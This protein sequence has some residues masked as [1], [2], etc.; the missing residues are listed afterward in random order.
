MAMP[1]AK[2]ISEPCRKGVGFELYELQYAADFV[3]KFGPRWQAL[4]DQL[5]RSLIDTRR[6]C[7]KTF[8]LDDAARG[9]VDAS[10][11]NNFMAKGPRPAEPVATLKNGTGWAGAGDAPPARHRKPSAD[12]TSPNPRFNV[13]G[14]GASGARCVE[15]RVKPPVPR[16]PRA[17]LSEWETRARSAFSLKGSA[18][19]L[20]GALMAAGDDGLDAAAVRAVGPWTPDSAKVFL[21]QLRIQLD[22]AEL[23]GAIRRTGDGWAIAAVAAASIE[24]RVAAARARSGRASILTDWE[25]RAQATFRFATAAAARLLSALLAAGEAGLSLREIRGLGTR[26]DWKIETAR[27]TVS[28]LR[29]GVQ[30]AG[31]PRAVGP[32][33]QRWSISPADAGRIKDMVG[34]GE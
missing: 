15:K 4:A 19:R 2:M 9:R 29:C 23:A 5:G 28:D 6:N 30:R 18:A 11:L 34:G 7:D 32:G 27:T 14:R 24:T 26:G 3:E 21:S 25:A 17:A 22:R 12:H 31:F 8:D 16:E 13:V 1:G 20:L 10:V 33:P